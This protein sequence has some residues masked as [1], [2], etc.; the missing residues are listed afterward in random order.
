MEIPHC[1]LQRYHYQAVK[2]NINYS[3]E[4]MMDCLQEEMSC[5][6][7]YSQSILLDTKGAE[8]EPVVKPK[9]IH[10]RIDRG[11]LDLNRRVTK[12]ENSNRYLLKK[13]KELMA[14]A[15]KRKRKDII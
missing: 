14:P 10:L 7:P 15:F 11:A 2:N 1:E 12:L 3:L 13:I 8:P 6:L 9:I 5:Y 4:G